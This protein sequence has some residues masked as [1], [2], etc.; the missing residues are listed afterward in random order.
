M[1][2]LLLLSLPLL[3]AAPGPAGGSARRRQT[4]GWRRPSPSPSPPAP[5]GAS[6][7][8]WV[9]LSPELVAVAPGH[10]VLLNCS[11]SCPPPTSF[12][13]YTRL[14]RGHKFAGPGWVSYELVNVTAWS[15]IVRCYVT[16][17]GETRQATARINAYREG[18]DSGR[19]GGRGSTD[20][21][22]LGGARGPFSEAPL[23]L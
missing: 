12:G 8:F 23:S 10:S 20:R 3:L 18:G 2:S 19:A 21:R 17:R 9:R 4:E 5:S 1:G 16:C 6:V 11:T 13:L 14:Q 22:P 15:S 7:P